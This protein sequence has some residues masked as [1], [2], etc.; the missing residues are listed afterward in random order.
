MRYPLKIVLAQVQPQEVPEKREK[1]VDVANCQTPV[2]EIRAKGDFHQTK[3]SSIGLTIDF[4]F[5]SRLACSAGSARQI[6]HLIHS[7]V[8]SLSPSY[9]RK[10]YSFQGENNSEKGAIRAGREGRRWLR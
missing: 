9:N 6:L 5:N 10:K 1:V 3:I 7:L 4:C 8:L 2:D